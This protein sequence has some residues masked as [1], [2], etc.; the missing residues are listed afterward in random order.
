M[1]NQQVPHHGV[2]LRT[3]TGIAFAALAL[4]LSVTLA[5]MT[6]ELTRSYLIAKR[7]NLATREALTNAH[8]VAT[9]LQNPAVDRAT[10]LPNLSSV[11]SSSSVLQLDGQWFTSA[12]DVGRHAI[13]PGL[14]SL[15]GNQTARQRVTIAGA[16]AIVVAVPI[17]PNLG[18]YYQVFSLTELRSTLR[19]LAVALAIAAAVTT[20]FGALIG[21]LASR[22]VLRPIDSMAQAAVSIAGG[23][24]ETRLTTRDPDLAPFVDSFNDMVDALQERVDH[25]ARFAADAS[26]EFRTP[27]TAIRAAIDVLDNR[28]DDQA[29]P[30]LEI[31]RRQ[32]NRFENLVLDL[33]EI[34]SLTP[35]SQPLVL[36]VIDPVPLVEGV[37]RRTAHTEI[38]IEVN[39][40]APTAAPIDCRRIERV[41]TNLIDNADH[42]ASGT[43]RAFS[44]TERR[45]LSRSPWMT[46]VRVFRSRSG[47]ARVRT[48]PPSRLHRVPQPPRVPGSGSQSPRNIVDYTAVG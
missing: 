46:P 9:L 7:E 48:L 22:R 20:L 11:G 5:V 28:V 15:R 3:K 14:Q 39:P 29:R 26:H 12:V 34:S 43:R 17:E 33:L 35:S 21:L 18:V 31:L 8:S 25:E 42:Y 38:P 30:A 45:I 40:S 6:Y 37:L 16:P 2:G 47:R 13:P 10:L 24:R 36:D 41:L 27:L 44:S 32:T 23:S 4:L 1:N 19:T